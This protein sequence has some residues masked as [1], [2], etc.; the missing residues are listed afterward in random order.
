VDG[1]K[2]RLVVKSVSIDDNLDAKDLKSQLN[3]KLSMKTWGVPLTAEI[4]L[5]DKA[6]GDVLDR[7]K[8]KLFD[9][10]KLTPRYSFIINGSEFQ[11]SNQLRLKPGAYIR[12]RRTGETEAMVNLEKGKNFHLTLDPNKNKVM[13]EIGSAKVNVYS[14]LQILGVHDK[15]IMD[16]LGKDLHGSLVTPNVDSDILKLH[17]SLFREKETDID[18]AA[19]R[20]KEY[21]KDTKISPETTQATLGH[22]FSSVTGDLLMRTVRKLVDVN[23]GKVEPDDRDEIRFKKLYTT[24]DLLEQRITKNVRPLQGRIKPKLDSS[25]EIKD[26]IQPRQIGKLIYAGR[27]E[28]ST[29]SFYNSSSLSQNPDQTNPIDFLSGFTKVTYLG[30]GGILDR[31]AITLPARNID[32]SHAGFLDPVHT[33]ENADIGV[34]NHIPLGVSKKGGEMKTR[35]QNKAGQ[36]LYLSAHEAHGQTIAM[37]GELD[38]KWRP[39]NGKKVMA[40]QA[41]EMVDVDPADVTYRFVDASDLFG[42]STNLIPFMS[43]NQGARAMMGAKMMPQAVPLKY[44]EAPL[45]QA[46]L[47]GGVSMD[48][49]IGSEFSYVAPVSGKVVAAKDGVISIKD[50]KGDTHD[51]QYYDN[52]PLN[53]DVGISSKLHIAVGDTVSKDQLIADTSFTQGGTL[54]MGK[55]LKIAYLPYKGYTFEDGVVVSQAASQKMT[56]EHLHR[57][58]SPR[59]RTGGVATTYDLK[60]FKAY[61]PTHFTS[62]QTNKLDDEGVVKI[63]ERVQHGDPL[64]VYLQEKTL[65]A[66]DVALGKLRKSLVKPYKNQEIT[67]DLEDE[68]VVTRIS[69]TPEGPVVWIKTEEPIKIGDKVAGRH[70]NK[71][72]ITM[73]VPDRE[74]PHTEGGEPVDIIMDPHGIP[75]RINVGQVYET[76][77]GKIAD[78]QGKPYLADS[79]VK[80]SYMDEITGHLKKEGLKDTEKLIDPN[81]GEV[82]GTPLVGYQY[83]MK[84]K[85]PVRSKFAGRGTDRYTMENRPAKGGDESAQSLDPLKMFSMLAHGAKSN[86]REMSTYKAERN[87]EFWRALQ[88]KQALPTPKPTF[89]WEKFV[90]MMRSAGVDVQKEGGQIRPIPLTDDEI[91]RMS[92]GAIKDAVFLRA[93]DLRP[94]EGGFFD[95]VMTG[96]VR[97][98]RW[99]HL[100]LTEA[101]PNPVFEEAIKVL[102]GLKQDELDDLVSG[103]AKVDQKGEFV[104]AAAEATE[105]TGGKAVHRMLSSIDMDADL[106][107]AT[108]GIQ[109]LKGAELNRANRKIRILKNLKDLGLRPEDAFILNHIPVIPP[110]YRPAYPDESGLI[111]ESPI[112]HLYKHLFLSNV[113]LETS[114]GLPLP[115]DRVRAREGLYNA[116]KVFQGWAEPTGA[117][118]ELMQGIFDTIAGSNQPKGGYF[119]AKLLSKRQDISGRSTIVLN[120]DLHMDQAG[121]PE[122]MGWRIFEPFVVQELVSTGYEVMDALSNVKDRTPAAKAAMQRVTETRPIILNRAPSL[123]KHSVMAFRPVLISGKSIELPPLVTK[124][125][126]ADFDGDTMSVEVPISRESVEEAMEMMPS[127]NMLSTS[128]KILTTPSQSSQ[129]GLYLLTQKGKQTDKKFAGPLEAFRAHAKGEVGDTDVIT[130]DG[131]VTTV[132]KLLVNAILPPKQQNHDIVLDKK[133]TQKILEDLAKNNP[134]DAPAVAEKL[135]DLGFRNAYDAGFS[136]ALSD[137][138][139]DEKGRDKVTSKIHDKIDQI[140]GQKLKKADR[141]AQIEKVLLEGQA[142]LMEHVKKSGKENNL[143]T[144]VRAGARGDW[145]QVAQMSAAPIAVEDA[146]GK[147]VPALIG[148]AYSEGLTPG[149][150]WNAMHGARKGMIERTLRTSEPGALNKSLLHNTVNYPVTEDDCGTH[151]GVEMSSENKEI[152]GRFLAHDAGKYKHNDLVTP[153]VADQLI[154]EG[155]KK[156]VARSPIT[157]HA[158]K[159]LCAKCAGLDEYGHPYEVG[160]NLGAISAQ[161]VTEPTTQLTMSTFHTGGTVSGEDKI[162]DSFKR[163]KSLMEFPEEFP[164]KATIAEVDGKV[165][166]ITENPVGGHNVIV[167]GKTHYIPA[168]RKLLVKHN[169]NVDKGTKLS[170]GTRDPR[171]ML[172]VLGPTKM[173]TALVEDLADVYKRAGPYVKQA[174][175]ETVVRAI[176]DSARVHDPGKSDYVSGDVVSHNTVRAENTKGVK[177]VSVDDALGAWLGEEINGLTPEKILTELDLDKLR[178]AGH[179]KVKANPDPIHYEPILKGIRT[180][181]LTRRDW[182]SQMAFTHL[183]DAIQKGIPEGWKSDLHDTNPIPGVIYGAEFGMGKYA[184][185][186]GETEEMIEGGDPQE[187]LARHLSDARDELQLHP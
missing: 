110:K 30:E 59:V 20:L 48:Q 183:K 57:V 62:D 2:N 157:C 94:V 68:G 129:L 159:G 122:E 151:A 154:K 75:S 149:E 86:I 187:M 3:A 60:K 124:G 14:L 121:I 93:K 11:V 101:M 119:Q 130:V 35:V 131:K 156:V 178:A 163:V 55:N 127:K 72:V 116:L 23:K 109:D 177:D 142:E 92:S 155:V 43:A 15:E 82:I 175:F 50:S 91:L 140:N 5:H 182:L 105:L 6:T 16:G 103:R 138:Q 88:M 148:H 143:A 96:G 169:E 26:I 100:A 65:T 141:E 19:A 134:I 95:P 123:H 83:I 186:G 84:L 172:R 12:K 49:A 7:Q 117:R 107:K 4:E 98:G 76:M 39:Q 9:I 168:D 180:L 70:G 162:V 63:G 24:D 36:V 137:F 184:S 115:E 37:P 147:I 104:K 58:E 185:D 79:F 139:V 133:Q 64:I 51:V 32:S 38:D 18:K 10:P 118:K 112:N 170:S 28:D 102:T 42:V 136:I 135:K 45:V 67:W 173:R 61:F 78:K 144:M 31:H 106:K 165:E 81:S 164:E 126:N 113:A 89:A 44:R 47:K 69:K 1:K 85:H 87:D 161:A 29:G 40:F 152:V 53:G 66:E 13:A 128:G 167:G 90:N 153:Q 80:H 174:H 166:S 125:F 158:P 8:V 114:K 22:P 56:S 146:T 33:P 52:F 73:I 150:Y 108:E 41:G 171:D 71:G 46:H 97:G 99:S 74:M 179:K 181:P 145:G 17:A 176:T 25:T 21:F 54:A 160:T 132:G 111:V 77:A 34:V 120:P 27:G